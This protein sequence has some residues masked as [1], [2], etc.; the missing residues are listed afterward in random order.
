MARGGGARLVAYVAALGRAPDAVAAFAQPGR[1]TAWSS[2]R[3]GWRQIAIETNASTMSCQAA[4]AILLAIGAGPLLLIVA[5]GWLGSHGLMALIRPLMQLVAM[6]GFVG[7]AA[8]MLRRRLFPR[9]TEFDGQVIRQWVLKGDDES[10]D[11][12]HVAV[13]DGAGPKAW[14][15]PVS[16]GSYGQLAPG[17]LVHVRVSL[18]KPRRATV[19]LVEPA[20][21]ARQLADPGVPHD[22]RGPG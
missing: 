7:I 4:L 21:A 22:P 16:S 13:D 11:E 2:Y 3:G 6:F 18:W 12:Y 10:P 9:F 19:S 20:A 5:A 15:L 17:A 8:W 1:D 14:D